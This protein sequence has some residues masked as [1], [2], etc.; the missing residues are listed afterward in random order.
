M[1]AEGQNINLP[2]KMVKISEVRQSPPP[3]C[4][5]FIFFHQ[6]LY[7]GLKATLLYYLVGGM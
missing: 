3:E 7:L 6:K 4:Q 2:V 5:N 1:S